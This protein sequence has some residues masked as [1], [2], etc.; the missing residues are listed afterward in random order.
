MKEEEERRP[1]GGNM[2]YELCG[3]GFSEFQGSKG[4]E[5]GEGGQQ[6]KNPES[7]KCKT[8]VSFQFVHYVQIFIKNIIIPLHVERDVEL[9]IGLLLIF[10]EYSLL[11][12]FFY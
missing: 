11:S 12:L 8:K 1:A 2:R 9:G 5:G 10:P 3:K 6:K 7:Q 4:G